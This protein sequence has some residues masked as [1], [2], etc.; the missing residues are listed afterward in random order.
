MGH[1]HVIIELSGVK[2]EV[3][4]NYYP[5]EDA[6][7]DSPGEAESVEIER[8]LT[9]KGDDIGELIAGN[10]D[11]EESVWWLAV[12]AYR[13]GRNCA[14]QDAAANRREYMREIGQEAA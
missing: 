5:G 6:S 2:L 3:I 10:K 1:L 13:D 9:P 12:E 11:L 7:F 4:G 14:A 8:V